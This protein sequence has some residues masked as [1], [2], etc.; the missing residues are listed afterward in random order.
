MLNSVFLN[1][2]GQIFAIVSAII[3]IPFVVRSYGV[4]GYGLLAVTMSMVGAVSAL[5][6]GFGRTTT[7][8]VS[9]KSAAGDWAGAVDTI[10]LSVSLQ[11]GIGICA[12]AICILLKHAVISHISIDSALADQSRSMIFYIAIAMPFTLVNSALRGALEGVGKFG[13]VNIVKGLQNSSLYVIPAVC[14]IV[15]FSLKDVV[16]LLCLSRVVIWAGYIYSCWRIFPGFW[17][18]RLAGAGT[19]SRIWRFS[20][21]VAVSNAAVIV[22]TNADKMLLVALAGTHAAGVYAITMEIVNGV[23]ILPGAV[24]SVLFPKFSAL[25]SGDRVSGKLAEIASVGEKWI[26]YA[27]FPVSMLLAVA[28]PW[29]LARWQGPAVGEQG[30]NAV[31]IAAA[32]IFVNSAGWIPTAFFLGI[33]RADIIAKIQLMQL[34]LLFGLGYLTFPLGGASA[35]VL[36]LLCRVG[37]EST[38]LLVLSDRT[39]RQISGSGFQGLLPVG[40]GLGIFASAVALFFF[41]SLVTSFQGRLSLVALYCFAHVLVCWFC[42]SNESERAGLLTAFDKKPIGT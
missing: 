12:A 18:I 6:L 15:G 29:L 4:G 39:L 9:E 32:V 38:V 26:G 7:K 27:I 17:S 33:G 3:G 22:L 11:A 16:A 30:A 25:A 42:I 8:F 2:V 40:G 28:G 21:W 24:T 20:G 37:L 1:L 36:V 41:W 13:I 34:P 23:S 10:W 5:D 31:R 19:D 14:G 35:G